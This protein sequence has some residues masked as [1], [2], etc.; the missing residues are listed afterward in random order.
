MLPLDVLHTRLIYYFFLST[1]ALAEQ[2]PA[3]PIALNY[4]DMFNNQPSGTLLL[5]EEHQDSCHSLSPLLYS[6]STAI[7]TESQSSPSAR[8]AVRCFTK[9]NGDTENAALLSKSSPLSLT[10]QFEK[11]LHSQGPPTSRGPGSF[12]ERTLIQMKAFQKT[13]DDSAVSTSPV[14]AATVT[15]EELFSHLPSNTPVRRTKIE[16][17]VQLAGQVPSPV[18]AVWTD[19]TISDRLWSKL[20]RSSQQDSMSSSSSISSSDTIIDLSL[21]N[22]VRKCLNS[23][24]TVTNSCDPTWVTCCHSP[25]STRHSVPLN[26][27]NSQPNL[28]QSQHHN[29]DLTTCL[30]LPTQEISVASRIKRI[31]RRHTWSRLYMEELKQS[32]ACG[33]LSATSPDSKSKSLGDLTSEDISCRFDSTYR[34]I[35]SSFGSRPTREQPPENRQ[36]HQPASNLTEQLRKLVSVEPL[37]AKDFALECKNKELEEEAINGSVVRRTSRSWSRVRYIA[38]RARKSQERQK[39]QGLLQGRSASFSFT[40]CAGSSSRTSPIKDQGTPE[41]ACSVARSTFTSEDLLGQ[42]SLLAHQSL[43]VSQLPADPDNTEVFFLLRL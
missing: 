39:I 11:T 20:K 29:D 37:T 22:P 38:N 25:S 18:P 12:M 9:E 30:T 5:P 41:G 36:K 34:S 8:E 27:S 33:L 15:R 40:T 4:E 24:S 14:P 13:N 17:C 35:S 21:P 26:E 10:H 3:P 32:S 28:W 1:D 31:Q 23:F 7:S 6:S 43:R 16:A 42:L 2:N 19:A